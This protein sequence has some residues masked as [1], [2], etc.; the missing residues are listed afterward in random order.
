V[1]RLIDRLVI[2]DRAQVQTAVTA[3]V[4]L[5]ESA[6]PA[7]VRRIDDRREMKWKAVSFENTSPDAFEGIAHYG[8]EDV[9]E[10]LDYVLSRL[11]GHI[12][13]V[14]PRRLEE[15]PGSVDDRREA[16]AQRAALVA[17]WRKYLVERQTMPPAPRKSLPS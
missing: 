15:S 6:V 12:V 16:D 14:G 4:M 2:N 9:L 10:C 13:D 8:A 7:I 1:A 17:G 3:L 5:G 11:T